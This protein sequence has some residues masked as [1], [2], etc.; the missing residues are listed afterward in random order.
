MTPFDREPIVV[1]TNVLISALLFKGSTA[2]KALDKALNN[3]SVVQSEDTL[4]ELAITVRRKKFD[5][6]KSIIEREQFLLIFSRAS[7]L[8]HTTHTVA[9]CRDPKDNKF[10]ELALSAGA[11][12]IV[13]GDDDLLSI[14][15]YCG[16]QIMKPKPFLERT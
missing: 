10:L 1:D 11:Q 13:T 14:H 5:A 12:V 16:V 8:I 9:D 15:P 3:Y 6:Y 4:R 2:A 7:T